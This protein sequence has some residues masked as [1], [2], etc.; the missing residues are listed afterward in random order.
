MKNLVVRTL[1]GAVLVAVVMGAILLSRWSFGALML[2]ITIGCMV[3]IYNMSRVAGYEPLTVMGVVASIC[4]VG[5]GVDGFFN[6]S[7]LS[8]PIALFLMAIVPLMFI[9]ECFRDRKQPMVNIALTLMPLLYIA[10][11]MALMVGVPVQLGGGEWN[12]LI[13]VAYFFVVW[14]NDSFAYLVGVSCGRHHICVRLS[15]KKTWEGLVGGIVG[16]IGIAVAAAHLLDGDLYVW[17]GMAVVISVSGIFGDLVESM[18]KRSVY[19][20]DSGKLLPGHGGWLDRFD[21]L[22]LSAPFVMVYLLLINFAK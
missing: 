16:S 12:P 15:P 22:I 11:P 5:F 1:S 10:A 7:E 13:M 14:A 8:I 20:K 6:S 9:V 17:G 2:A 18:F 3:E 4:V 19:I 21:A